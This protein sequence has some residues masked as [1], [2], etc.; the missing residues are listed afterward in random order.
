MRLLSK[1][2]AMLTMVTGLG[3]ALYGN[4]VFEVV[5]GHALPVP[6]A[7][8]SDA[9]AIWSGVAFA[10]IAGA[11]ILCLGAVLWAANQAPQ[12]ESL[13]HRTLFWPAVLATLVTLSQQEAIWSATSGVVLVGLFAVIAVTTGI[14]WLS[15]FTDDATE[16]A[17]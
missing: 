17:A 4:L 14:R 13:M 9:M 12:R 10:R 3:M 8:D 7:E 15:P 5:S 16:D 2:I 11:A 6:V 1:M